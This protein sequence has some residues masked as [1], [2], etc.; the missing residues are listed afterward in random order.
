MDPTSESSAHTELRRLQSAYADIVT[1]R[2]WSELSTILRPDCRVVVD[3]RSRAVSLDGPVAVG[4]FIA[5]A[6]ARFEFFSFAVL[7]TVMEIDAAAGAAS[8]RMYMQELRQGDPPGRYTDA[9][10]VYHD[11]FV[12]EDGR[13]W[14]AARYYRSFARTAADDADAD[15]EVFDVPV[16]PLDDPDSWDERVAAGGW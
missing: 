15:L 10:G 5:G 13:W 3:T 4:E 9:Y 2:A 11:R 12:R 8:A 14:F 16:L 7:N 1:R 6:V